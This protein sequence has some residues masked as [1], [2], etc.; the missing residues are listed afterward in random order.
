M[1]RRLI[2]HIGDH[3]T[4]STS[5][6]N[7]LA[8]GAFTAGGRRVLYPTSL[9]HNY[10]PALIEAEAADGRPRPGTGDRPGPARLA[11]TIAASDADVAIISGEVFE[12]LDPDLLHAAV[13]R[14]FRGTADE[15]RVIA[16]VRPHAARLV[17]SF[18]EQVKIGWFQGSLDD[19][20]RKTRR[21]RRFIYHPRFSRLRA[22]FGDA[23]TLRPM[24]RE[25]LWQGCVVHD[26]LATA[27]GDRNL[28][29]TGPTT[30]NSSLSVEDL[31]VLS[32]VQAR[33]RA[34]GKWG[35][36]ALGWTFSRLAAARPAKGT[37][38]RLHRALA[39]R[40]AADHAADAEAM[41]RDFFGGRP[42]LRGALAAAVETASEAPVPLA[43][44]ALFAPDER[45]R[46]EL[47][48]DLVAEMYARAP[49]GWR[50]H[51]HERRLEALFGP[52]A[53]KHRADKDRA[54]GG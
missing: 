27:L 23:F 20:A 37:R 32:M 21:N 53:D 40:V 31:A 22:L 33:L 28:A 17:S 50:P 38:L 26:F 36:H 6:Q 3:K 12:N 18:A 54:A 47:M 41:D 4:G 46:L 16:Y 34:H 49:K 48:A 24:I 25:E 19:F 10:L 29:V 44:E 35:R 51:F 45:R 8:Q 42:L 13:E 9:N 5:I 30:D 15:I 11:R 1:V 7:I 2:F 39:E 43:P 14:H 52:A